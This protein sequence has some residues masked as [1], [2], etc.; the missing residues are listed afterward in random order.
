MF[1]GDLSESL[2]FL[3]SCICGQHIDAPGLR[4]D[5]FVDT[6]EI[7]QVCGVAL[8]RCGIVPIVA[9]ARSRSGR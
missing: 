1:F 2:G 9:T 7:G 5:R 8:Q 4:P 3:D 6:V